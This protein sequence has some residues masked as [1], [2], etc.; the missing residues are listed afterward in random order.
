MNIGVF[1]SNAVGLRA[2]GSRLNNM[3]FGG[4][5]YPPHVKNGKTVNA[6]WEG[7][8]FLNRRDY[9]DA[10]NQH[11]EGKS[12]T[13]RI[14]VWNS[15]NAAPGKGLADVFAKC[16]SVGKEI[17]C[18]LDINT[19]DKR[20]FVN[21]QPVTDPQGNALTYPAVNFKV[22]GDV[23]FGADS[24]STVQSEIAAYNGQ[25]NFCSRPQFWNVQSH[26]DNT[27]WK[28]IVQQRMAAVCDPNKPSYGY[29][30]IVIPEGA[31]LVNAAA[32]AQI[33][34]GTAPTQAAAMIIGAEQT[35]PATPA[36]TDNIFNL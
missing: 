26:A 13:I 14:V 11:H 21:G 29:A 27:A 25:A 3:T 35:M 8:M 33:P 32:P 4:V 30:R 24:D 17:S 7:I 22:V 19:F 20:L 2:A 23:V 15:P 16:I 18:A 10:N 1:H 34:T 5:Y 12:E 9:T 28:T 6:R 31:Q 36:P